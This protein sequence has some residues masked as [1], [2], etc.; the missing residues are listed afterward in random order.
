MAAIQLDMATLAVGRFAKFR[1]WQIG[2]WRACEYDATMNS[3]VILVNFSADSY[4]R[5]ILHIAA[6]DGSASQ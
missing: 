3:N 2:C 4:L 1:L 5:L 6:V